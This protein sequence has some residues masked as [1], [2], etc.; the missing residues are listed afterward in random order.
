MEIDFNSNESPLVGALSLNHKMIDSNP[1]DEQSTSSHR[2]RYPD[3][4]QQILEPLN[5]DQKRMAL[6][7]SLAIVPG[8]FPKASYRDSSKHQWLNLFTL[9]IMP[10]ASGKSVISSV[11]KIMEQT[12]RNLKMAKSKSVVFSSTDA[13]AEV[14]AYFPD[15]MVS[16]N[17]TSSK[18]VEKLHRNNGHPLIMVE[19]EVD[20][21]INASRGENGKQLSAILRKAAE[22]ETISQE[23]RRNGE[24][25]EASKPWLSVVLSGTPNQ[26]MGLFNDGGDGLLSRF[27]LLRGSGTD[28]WV[29][30]RPSDDRVEPLEK[31]YERLG[32][33]FYEIYSK[34]RNTDINVEFTSQQWDM[35]DETGK[36]WERFLV[37]DQD[38]NGR[39]IARRGCKQ[40]L[41]IASI[42]TIL[43]NVDM[44]DPNL[45]VVLTC[46]QTDFHSAVALMESHI[47]NSFEFY[48]ELKQTQSRY[49]NAEPRLQLLARLPKSFKR[50][51]AEAL[52]RKMG[53]AARTMDRYLHQMVK[54][55]QVKVVSHGQYAKLV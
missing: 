24:E 48:Q 19:T 51:E 31:Y 23:R 9:I 33:K 29:S 30:S 42:L 5:E 21:L 55:K 20:T 39:S 17:I 2:S 50:M 6:L 54:D 28:K 10:P 35:L 47:D 36:A 13:S 32:H 46:D 3:L 40:V 38:Y 7:T 15:L 8:F 44:I 11:A 12:Q 22:Q 16:S 49:R 27:I 18:L 45:N 14:Q 1:R 43:R 26:L 53:I 34:F 52:G 37:T 41:K 4:L 25:L